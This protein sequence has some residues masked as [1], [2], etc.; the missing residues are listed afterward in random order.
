MQLFSRE[1]FPQEI[2]TDHGTQFTSQEFEAFLKDR[3]ITHSFSSVY[4]PQANGAIERFNVILKNAI[5]NA[6]IMGSPIKDRVM[7]LLAVYRATPH[8][9][10]RETPCL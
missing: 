2:V 10:M 1:G 5:Q 9:T 3:D 7:Q 6:I 4:Y 8:S